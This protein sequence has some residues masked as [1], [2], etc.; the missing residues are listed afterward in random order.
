M[1]ALPR[2]AVGFLTALASA[3]SLVAQQ[4][5]F[6]QQLGPIAPGGGSPALSPATYPTYEYATDSPYGIAETG[7]TETQA[8]QPSQALTSPEGQPQDPQAAAASAEEALK[9][10]GEAVE[11]I[12]K[13]VTVVT[14]KEDWKVV[15]FG[16]LKG[17][18]IFASARPIPTSSPF[19]LSPDSPFGFSQDT[20]DIHGKSTTLGA[21][22][23]GPDIC[24]Y[25]AG[26]TVLGALYSET[27]V[28]DLYGF[29]PLMAYGELKNDCRRWSAGLQFDVFNPLLPGMINFNNVFASGNTGLYRGQLRTERY[30]YPSWDSQVTVQ[31][32]IG[33]PLP[34]N[35]TRDFRLSEPTGWPN[36]DVRCAWAL[37]PLIGEGPTAQRPF[38]VGVSTFA[39]RLRT[40]NLLGQRVVDDTWGLGADLRHRVNERFGFQ[41]EVFVGQGMGTYGGGALQTINTLT[42]EAIQTS[43]G[44]AEVYYYTSPCVHI[45][46]GAGVDDPLDGDVTAAQILRNETYFTTW[47]WDV[48]EDVRL[49]VELSYRETS[50]HTLLDNNAVLVHTQMLVRF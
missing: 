26:G 38:E 31:A 40:V 2:L 43:G 14:G 22:V 24:G 35:V 39:G 12:G 19:F 33:D 3:S 28:T 7:Q 37:G 16:E 45:H 9:K 13:N 34:T 25:K 6:Q 8:Q 27:L 36:L 17:E 21:M 11:T 20:V 32:A 29:L 23:M 48:T 10:L 42:F 46:I 50:Y 47:F 5:T 18:A 1:K 15:L 30:F 49:G 44:W 41:G 4:G